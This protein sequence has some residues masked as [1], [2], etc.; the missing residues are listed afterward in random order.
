MEIYVGNLSY[1]TEESSLKELFEAYGQ[2]AKVNI[3]KDKMTGQSKGFGFVSM[4]NWKS[5]KKAIDELNGKELDGRTLVINQ[6]RE[7]T[8]RPQRKEHRRHNRR[9]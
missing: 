4:D 6:A 3:I 1:T 9:Y 2:V 8:E 7:R 5:A